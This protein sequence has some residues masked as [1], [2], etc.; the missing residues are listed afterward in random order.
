LPRTSP[1]SAD[2]EDRCS[3]FGSTSERMGKAIDAKGTSGRL[4]VEV[5]GKRFVGKL[6][7]HDHGHDHH[8]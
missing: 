8:H 1:Q 6:G 5:S 4:N 7:G 2:P 3:A